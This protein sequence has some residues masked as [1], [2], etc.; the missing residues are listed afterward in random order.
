[1]KI[2]ISTCALNK[3]YS[4]E[5][6][7]EKFSD[8]KIDN[9]ELTSGRGYIKNIKDLLGKYKFN[10]FVHNYF[11]EPESPFV[12]NFASLD[13]K[14]RIK[15]INQAFEGIKLS[16]LLG[17]PHY[18]I[19]A[20]FLYDPDESID[21]KTGLFKVPVGNYYNKEKAF[22]NYIDALIMV[23]NYSTSKGIKLLVENNVC[24][25]GMENKLILSDYEDFK[26]LFE[27]IGDLEIGILLDFGHLKVSSKTLGFSA[28]EFV[29]KLRDYISAFHI[30]D[31]DGIK[32]SHGKIHEDSWSI[33]TI[34]NY[35]FE[36]LP[37]TLEVN[38][39][40]LEEVLEQK[41]L[42]ENI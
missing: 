32:D 6:V 35:S 22:K 42:L 16:S 19:H 12:L 23:F 2:F 39:L 36:E 27:R 29:E 40:K 26:E 9:V 15:S 14:V 4:L 1:M 33:K 31:N 24:A 18:A 28:D 25:K 34:K 3:S 11:P 17:S 8:A 10:Y 38:D 37:I 5:E 41:K 7:L 30:H 13:D 20:G 21:E